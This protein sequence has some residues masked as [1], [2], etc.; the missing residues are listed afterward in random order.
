MSTRTFII[1]GVIA[2]CGVI[3]VVFASNPLRR[4]EEGISVWLET[5]TPLGSSREA[6]IAY[7]QKKKWYDS[8]MQGSDGKTRGEFVRGELGEYR[9]IFVTS[10]TVFWEFNSASRLERIRVWKTVDAL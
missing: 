3:A 10:V 4:S 1:S 9:T 5:Q 2:V 6:V 8:Y 7:A